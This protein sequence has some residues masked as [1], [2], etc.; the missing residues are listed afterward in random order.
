M[1]ARELAGLPPLLPAGKTKNTSFPTQRLPPTLHEHFLADQDSSM[2]SHPSLPALDDIAEK[3]T[4]EA[5]AQVKDSAESSIAGAARDKMLTVRKTKRMISSSFASAADQG[6][7]PTFAILAV[8]TFVL[9]LIN[10]FWLY[11]RDVATSPQDRFKGA[12]VGGRAGAAALLDP[13]ILS[14]YL[15][16]LSVLLNAAQNSP[17]FLVVL[18]PEVLE[19]VLS[20][21]GAESADEAV[22]TSILQLIL[23]VLDSST[24]MDGGRTLAQ[25]FSTLTWQIKDWTECM[26]NEK[27]QRGGQ[28]DQAGRAAAGILLKLDSMMQMTIGYR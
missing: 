18:A 20:L 1:G 25:D 16:T 8:D 17:H 19:L 5:L 22:R 21:R 13:L 28:I 6:S 4:N 15:A 14:K 3:I 10:R 9:P 12:Y 27:E 2:M 7:H 24:N 11:M 26:W 23:V